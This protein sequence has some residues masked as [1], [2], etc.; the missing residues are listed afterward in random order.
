VPRQK[1]GEKRKKTVQETKKATSQLTRRNI[2]LQ[3]WGVLQKERGRLEKKR[4]GGKKG[5]GTT[6]WKR[7]EEN[8]VRDMMK[9]NVGEDERSRGER[10]RL[11][12]MIWTRKRRVSTNCPHRGK[13]RN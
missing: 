8:R 11:L 7:F 4:W 13:G 12:K 10:R 2:G 3:G 9:P 6:L 5:V 1:Q